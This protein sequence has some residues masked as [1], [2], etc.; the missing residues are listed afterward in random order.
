[1]VGKRSPTNRDVEPP[2]IDNL[3]LINGIGPGVEKRM[4]G[5]GI[6]TFAQLAALSPADLAAALADLI[7]LSSEHI[8]KQD[9]IGQARK[10]AAESTSFE[11]Q[12]NAEPAAE[13]PATIEHTH[14]AT[15]L[16]EPQQAHK[17]TSES[18]S[19]KTKR[20]LRLQRTSSKSLRIQPRSSQRHL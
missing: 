10:L 1:M 15:P 5:V 2:R 3:K 7:G 19:S 18:T 6:F 11:A 4:N 14:A 20:R 13:S 16:L 17:L 8:I 12:K 9:W